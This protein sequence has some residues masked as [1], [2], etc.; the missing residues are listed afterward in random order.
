M[1]EKTDNQENCGKYT[2][3]NT[4]NMSNEDLVKYA[5][6]VT[7]QNLVL[8]NVELYEIIQYQLNITN[9]TLEELNPILEEIADLVIR[10]READK[11]LERIVEMGI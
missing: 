10:R 8:I 4:P 2:K 3:D 5:K 9:K 6:R 11:N 7:E 1:S